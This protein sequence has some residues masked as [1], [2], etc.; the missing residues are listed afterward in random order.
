MNFDF[1]GEIPG[2]G[3]KFQQRLLTDPIIWMRPAL[4]VGLLILSMALP[5]LPGRRYHIYLLVMVPGIFFAIGVLRWPGLGPVVLIVASLTVPFT[6]GTGTETSINITIML[7][8]F[9]IG[10]W[11][12]GMVAKQGQIIFVKSRTFLPLVVF[13]VVVIAAFLFGQLPWFSFA[14][15][16]ASISA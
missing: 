8:V 11:L 16:S 13:L 1:K 15:Q 6:V 9:L 10:L 14:R 5:F 7:V 2:F 4:V 3:R 12:F